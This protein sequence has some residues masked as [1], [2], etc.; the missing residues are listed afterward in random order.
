MYV[1]TDFWMGRG[2]GTQTVLYALAGALAPTQKPL[3]ALYSLDLDMGKLPALAKPALAATLQEMTLVCS[4]FEMQHWV[5]LCS[6][7]SL[8]KGVLKLQRLAPLPVQQ[9]PFTIQ[10]MQLTSLEY[11]QFTSTSVE[12]AA[13]LLAHASALTSLATLYFLD[14]SLGTL[15]AGVLQLPQL[16]TLGMYNCEL[17]QLPSLEP[18][19]NLV[20]LHLPNNP[21]LV[22]LRPALGARHQLARLVLQGTTPQT[23]ATLEALQ[24]LSRLKILDVSKHSWSVQDAAA[25][26]SLVQLAHEKGC[27]LIT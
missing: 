22:D 13:P 18:L 10:N 12:V 1:D 21:R 17:T 11:L 6:L 19:K 16:A 14:C 26:G 23:E 8:R 4:E 2:L 27:K 7:R 20:E 24:G 5:P 9:P 3:R 25:L 15:P